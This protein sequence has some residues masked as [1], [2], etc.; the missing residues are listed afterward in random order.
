MMIVLSIL[1]LACD[2]DAPSPAAPA[3]PEP[4]AQ[5]EA[6]QP[7][8]VV[9]VSSSNTNQ[10]HGYTGTFADDPKLIPTDVAGWSPADFRIKRNEIFARYGRAFQS[11]DLQAHFGKTSWYT[12][13]EV[14]SDAML[15]RND[16]ANVALIKSFEGETATQKAP[17][18]GEYYS[19]NGTNL[20]IIDGT[21][22]ELLDQ[23]D[24]M[25]NW[26]AEK[27]YWV[28]LGEWVITWEGPQTWNPAD[29][30]VRNATLWKLNHTEQRIEDT[31]ALKPQQG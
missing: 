10:L 25:Y 8:P 29:T 5:P 7:P 16:S 19:D 13:N 20:V 12:V 31:F 22:A 23:A 11:E 28:G 30:S 3:T 6:A 14:F 2:Q 1:L 17:Q 21:H 26:T 15:T 4:A 18:N 24:D 9:P 27:R